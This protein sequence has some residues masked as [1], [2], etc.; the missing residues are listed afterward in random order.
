[1]EWEHLFDDLEG[2]LAAEWEAQRAALDAESERLRVSKLSLH[3]RLRVMFAGA[4]SLA[5]ELTAGERWSAAPK[6]LGA[7]WLGVCVEGD[8]RLRIVPLAAV[9]SIGLDHGR[10]L[11]SLAAQDAARSLRERMGFGFVLRDLARRR[12]PV[13]I[14]TRS[15][16]TLHGTIDRAGVDHLDLA[17]HDPGEPRRARGVSGFRLIPFTAVAW[18]RLASGSADLLD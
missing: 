13:Q 1:V 5:L 3:D 16:A 18:L 2:Q 7:D 14:T 9:Q 10:L 17:M 15:G 4:E 8:P 12:S 11:S 6:A